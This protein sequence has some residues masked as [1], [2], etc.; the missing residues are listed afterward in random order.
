MGR[1]RCSPLACS[2]LALVLALAVGCETYNWEYVPDA[3]VVDSQVDREICV[4]PGAWPDDPQNPA[5]R[6]YRISDQ[7]AIRV[8]TA[9]VRFDVAYLETFQSFEDHLRGLMQQLVDDNVLAKDKPNLVQFSEH[10]GL[11][12]AFIGEQGKEARKENH[13]RLRLHQ[14][15]RVVHA[16]AQLLHELRLERHDSRRAR[17]PRAHRHAVAVVLR[18]LQRGSRRSS[19]STSSLRATSAGRSRS[20]RIRTSSTCSG[21]R[22]S[23]TPLMSTSPRTGTSTT[24]PTLSTR[25]A[26]SS[27]RRARPT[28][29]GARRGTWVSASGTSRSWRPC[30]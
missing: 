13:H 10:I 6:P 24:R 8:F 20:P 12:A 14:A 9:Q 27:A 26:R 23:R 29:W 4:T 15:A 11:A 2:L 28:W 21:P 7:D 25:T 30:R 17:P 1:L 19:T 18:E 3:G 22:T 5:A 16:A